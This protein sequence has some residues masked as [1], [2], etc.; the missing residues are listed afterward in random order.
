MSGIVW[1]V[2]RNKIMT[3][4]QGMRGLVGRK[5]EIY[6]Y[7]RWY[8]MAR[9]QSVFHTLAE[10]AIADFKKIHCNRELY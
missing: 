2:Y 3:A 5:V 8:C 10:E 1:G 7:V 9:D 4:H 6:S